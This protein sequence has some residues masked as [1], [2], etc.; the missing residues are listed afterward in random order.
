MTRDVSHFVI[1]GLTLVKG[2]AACQG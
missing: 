1:T 2:F